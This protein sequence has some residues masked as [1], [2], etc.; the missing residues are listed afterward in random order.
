MRNGELV[1]SLLIMNHSVYKPRIVYFRPEDTAVVDANKFLER[2]I[3]TAY[4]VCRIVDATKQ[5]LD[6]KYTALENLISTVSSNSEQSIEQLTNQIN[7]LSTVS[8]THSAYKAKNENDIT[9][10]NQQIS[11][12]QTS[13]AS[14]NNSITSLNTAIQGQQNDIAQ[15]T[16]DYNSLQQSVTEL[17]HTMYPLVI[18]LS[19]GGIY[20]KGTTP[21][22]TLSWSISRNGV[23]ITPT[24]QKINN[25]DVTSPKTFNPT[26]DTTYTLYITYNEQ[27]ANSSVNVKFVSP[28]YCGV[29]SNDF[30]ATSS[31]II[32]L[33]KTIKDTSR[34]DIT[35]SS[36]DNQKVCYAYPK[37][38]GQLSS[39]K[40]SNGFEYISSYILS[41]VT[42][43]NIEYNVYLL[44]SATSITNF[45]QSYS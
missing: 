13:I 20:E 32:I 45:K 38:F 24:T 16:T 42:I 6:A 12:I 35:Y 31:N 2:D 41:T 25:I 34:F 43:N 1:G 5:I 30:Q 26:I 3:L 28:S 8:Q 39:I 37:S 40:D 15:L 19:G 17:L 27:S 22:V 21:T 9:Y 29:V 10:I 4:S 14:T 36:L 44:E 33:N 18:S 23:T 7:Q 11:S